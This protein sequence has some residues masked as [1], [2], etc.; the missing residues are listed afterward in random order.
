LDNSLYPDG[1]NYDIINLDNVRGGGL[2]LITDN[3]NMATQDNTI[4]WPSEGEPLTKQQYNDLRNYATAMNIRLENF[5]NSDVD[6]DLIKEVID[7]AVKVLGHFPELYGSERKLLT[8]HLSEMQNDDFAMVRMH[9]PHILFLSEKAYRS[10]IALQNEYN[11]L[12]ETGWFVK[13][14]DYH[15]II[16]HEM[17][18][19]FDYRHKINM[20]QIMK[21]VLN[22]KSKPDIFN[23]LE[24]NL[25]EYSISLTNGSEIISET[26]SYFYSTTVP[27]PDFVLKI[28]EKFIKER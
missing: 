5:K 1:E 15:S 9:T 14:T 2:P 7:D 23:Y 18:H 17:G 13:G 28:M 11:K 12:A 4:N 25:S 21:D 24:S 20:I 22:K 10:K 16:Y 19:M 26:F 3:S 8:I 6:V 27:K